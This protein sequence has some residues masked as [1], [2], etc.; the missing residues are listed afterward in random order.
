[1]DIVER[2]VAKR[3]PILQICAAHGADNVRIF[4]SCAR[5]DYDEKSDVDILVHFN[6]KGDAFNYLKMLDLLKSDLENILDA[7]V[8]I[9]DEDA[10]RGPIR[11]LIFEEAVAL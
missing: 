8:D 11:E 9:L 1:M 4:G 7:K 10:L 2:I 6:S 5:N 3:K